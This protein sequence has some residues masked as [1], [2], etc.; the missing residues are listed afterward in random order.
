L[1]WPAGFCFSV[2]VAFGVSSLLPATKQDPTDR[3]RL[4]RAAFGMALGTA[5]F[6]WLAGGALRGEEW[7]LLS[8][9][10]VAGVALLAGGSHVRA[11]GSVLLVVALASNLAVR[12]RDPMLGL[13]RDAPA[14]ISRN[15]P[16]FDFVA[17]RLTVSDRIYTASVNDDY[18]LMRKSA[19]LFGLNAALDYE[20]L[21]SRR[22]AEY[23]IKMMYGAGAD[24]WM[25]SVHA[26]YYMTNG[27]PRNRSLLNLAGVR[28]L[29]VDERVASKAGTALPFEALERFGGVTVYD[30]AEALPRAFF[31]PSLR[32]VPDWREKL[33]TLASR[34][35]SARSAALVSAPP[36]DGH[37]AFPAS[38][39]SAE[40]ESDRSEELRLRAS[41]TAGG[42]VFV[43]DQYYPGWTATVNGQ[44]TEIL[45]AN[46]AFRAVRIPAGAS[47]V[48]FRYR[49]LSVRIGFGI[50]AAAFVLLVMAWWAVV[51]G[52]DRGL[53]VQPGR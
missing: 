21:T 53:I 10:L 50:S 29:V 16:A 14:E 39:G 3:S 52:R 2:V 48:V 34:S 47:E 49:P 37:A 11:A 43:S 31:V 15:E 42:F 18:G 13:L 26:F 5:A 25:G 7:V 9:V 36:E 23:F 6:L 45:V 41:S 40:I 20:P 1:H 28:I 17:H 38:E 30:N 51:R 32:V 8:V 46:H 27:V 12:A 35:F 22:F 19:S 4:V 24:P 33:R 44:P